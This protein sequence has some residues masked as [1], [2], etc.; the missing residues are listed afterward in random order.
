MN[1]S[2]RKLERLAKVSALAQR[3]GTEGERQAAINAA[4]RIRGRVEGPKCEK[5]ITPIEALQQSYADAL[6]RNNKRDMKRIRA[7]LEQVKR[8]VEPQSDA[9][10][11]IAGVYHAKPKAVK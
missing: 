10:A 8:I 5:P 1:M 2:K 4:H 9:C 11:P 3:A 7:E 6:R